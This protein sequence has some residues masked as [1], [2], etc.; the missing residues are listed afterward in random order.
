MAQGKANMA[1]TSK[2][3]TSKAQAVENKAQADKLKGFEAFE[4]ALLDAI[5]AQAIKADDVQALIVKAGFAVSQAEHDEAKPIDAKAAALSALSA[6]LPD[7]ATASAGTLAV[8]IK[9]IAAAFGKYG[10]HVFGYDANNGTSLV[11]FSI[12]EQ[13]VKTGKA[14]LPATLD[15]VRKFKP[16]YASSGH[17]NTC[18]KLLKA[19]GFKLNVAQASFSISA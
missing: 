9:S 18:K 1:K 17:Y 6:F 7:H 15:F 5:K 14:S 16:E 10:K 19:H 3:Q 11:T 12:A 8:D 2:A 4:K 13:L